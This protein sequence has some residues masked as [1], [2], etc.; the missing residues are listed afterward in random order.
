MK[1]TMIQRSSRIWLEQTLW[2]SL[3]SFYMRRACLVRTGE[4]YPIFYDPAGR[5]SRYLWRLSWPLAV[6]VTLM[7][8][9]F[10][11][12]VLVNPALPQ[13]NLRQISSL[14]G[15]ADVRPKA[16]PFISSRSE[17]KAASSR[18]ALKKALTR[19]QVKPPAPAALANHP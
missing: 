9:V 14:P 18:A 19:T 8:A 15:A 7:A 4:R 16:P 17:Q 3:L 10:I 2:R 6:I 5:R 1:R 13:L 11:A 12:S